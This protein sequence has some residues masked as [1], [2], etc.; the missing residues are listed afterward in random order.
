MFTYAELTHD[1]DWRHIVLAVLVVILSFCVL[2]SIWKGWSFQP[3]TTYKL[4][5]VIPR[6]KT[7]KRAYQ[8]RT[9]V[10]DNEDRVITRQKCSKGERECR[11]VLEKIFQVPFPTVEPAWLINPPTGERMEI[12]AYNKEIGIGLEYHGKQHY[13]QSSFNQSDE[14]FASQNA[15]DDMKFKLC[16][17]NGVYLI[18]VPYTVPLSQI[19]EYIT[20]YLP[21]NRKTRLDNGMTE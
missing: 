1:L 12:D 3:S 7:T 18:T 11:R 17:E 14:E 5:T 9:K 2:W 13:S 20:Y 6:T 15:R 10:N 19:E 16:Q 8:K 4:P 21:W